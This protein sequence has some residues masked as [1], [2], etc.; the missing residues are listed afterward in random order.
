MFWHK[1]ATERYKR[2]EFEY[3]IPVN[4]AQIDATDAPDGAIMFMQQSWLRRNAAETTAP[5]LKTGWTSLGTVQGGPI[6]WNGSNWYYHAR[7]SWAVASATTRATT[8]DETFSDPVYRLWQKVA[9]KS[10]GGE[11]LTAT[12]K[13]IG[14]DVNFSAASAP[15]ALVRVSGTA[16]FVYPTGTTP[17]AV[18]A[19]YIGGEVAGGDG[20][21]GHFV[22]TPDNMSACGMTVNAY[23]TNTS[24][25]TFIDLF[26]SGVE[27]TSQDAAVSQ[28]RE[29][30]RTALL[31]EAS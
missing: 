4:K 26:A 17:A 25:E 1:T 10:S 14:D 23:L 7:V 15:C 8:P 2:G 16:C 24:A 11:A 19:F 6:S 5:T 21:V 27:T 18:S 28:E 30:V 22:D 20:N 9:V 3:T 29:H 13:T 12:V 31:I